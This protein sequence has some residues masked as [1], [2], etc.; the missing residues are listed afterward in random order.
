MQENQKFRSPLFNVIAVLLACGLFGIVF[1]SEGLI[2]INKALTAQKWPTTQGEIVES[3]FRWE[4][5]SS[6]SG[7]RSG[8]YHLYIKYVYFINNQRYYS[9]QIGPK[10]HIFSLG[11][12][13]S[14]QKNAEGIVKQF[15][16]GKKV[17]VW[18]NPLNP[19][20]A[21]LSVQVKLSY[22][23]IAMAGAFVMY[24]GYW[25]FTKRKELKF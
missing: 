10:G 18:Y 19:Q 25:I 6:T 17:T 1:M 22:W 15:P 5:S 16:K 9:D 2:T 8:A 24:L 20:E 7:H 4:E 3:N 11:Q 13:T 12:E 14:F 21:M 23:L